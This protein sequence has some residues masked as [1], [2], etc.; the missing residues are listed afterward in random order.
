MWLSGIPMALHNPNVD[1]YFYDNS[2]NGFSIIP[3]IPFDHF[4][5]QVIGISEFEAIDTTF[6]EATSNIIPF[7]S[8][9]HSIFL[10]DQNSLLY[11]TIATLMEKISRPSFVGSL[12][13]SSLDVWHNPVVRFNYFFNPKDLAWCVADV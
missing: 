2:H 13:L 5:I 3:S 12:S 7:F 6:L 11:V 1:N 9:S 4:L 8:P 10:H